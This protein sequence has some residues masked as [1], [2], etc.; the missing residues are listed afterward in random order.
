MNFIY[1]YRLLLFKLMTKNLLSEDKMKELAKSVG[2]DEVSF[3]NYFKVFQNLYD[4]SIPTSFANYFNKVSLFELENI[5]K[6]KN[7]DSF[8]KA[9][10]SFINEVTYDKKKI[11]FELT[12]EESI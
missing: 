9:I 6:I 4:K 10:S 5:N 8:L 11:Y 1:K 2:A 3:V 12:N 7:K